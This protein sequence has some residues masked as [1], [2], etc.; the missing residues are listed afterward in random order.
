MSNIESELNRIWTEIRRLQHTEIAQ[1]YLPF[2]ANVAQ[3]IA[4]T[5]TLGIATVPRALSVVT[6]K[7]AALV[8]TTNNASNYWTIKLVAQD[9]GLDITNATVNTSAVAADVWNVLTVTV[10]TSVASTYDAI[11]AYATKTLN[12][13]S[14]Y[15]GAPLVTY[16]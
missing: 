12:P 16:T 2:A 9:G 13:G 7:I 14:L 5:N 6:F 3:P 11:Y 15:W 10:G 1:L 8:I 4:A